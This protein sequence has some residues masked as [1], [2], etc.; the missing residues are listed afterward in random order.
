MLLCNNFSI[1]CLTTDLS[2]KVMRKKSVTSASSPRNTSAQPGDRYGVTSRWLFRKHVGAARRSLWHDVTLT[3]RKIQP[4]PF[5]HVTSI[6]W[7]R[8]FMQY[9]WKCALFIVIFNS[10][11]ILW[12]LILQTVPHQI[13][14]P[15]LLLCGSCPLCTNLHISL[16][17]PFPTFP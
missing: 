10:S 16:H 4:S 17:V 1:L 12:L 7:Y 11:F 14:Y 15:V 8:C 5:K 3:L 9:A 6:I 13:H 2:T